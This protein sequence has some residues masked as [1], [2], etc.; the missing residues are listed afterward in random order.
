[1]RQQATDAA[2]ALGA[3]GLEWFDLRKQAVQKLQQGVCG[4]YASDQGGAHASRRFSLAMARSRCCHTVQPQP[5]K[6]FFVVPEQNVCGLLH[7]QLKLCAIASRI[8]TFAYGMT[9]CCAS[10]D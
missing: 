7:K 2:D 9:S 1:M 3:V 4:I 10:E 6:I 5:A 8:Q